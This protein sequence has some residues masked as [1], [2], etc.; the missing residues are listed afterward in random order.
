MPGGFSGR[1]A[2]S[3]LGQASDAQASTINTVRQTPSH[4]VASAS[5]RQ[6]PH[7]PE[8]AATG[9]FTTGH[10]NSGNIVADWREYET[11]SS[12]ISQADEKMGECLYRAAQE[13]EAMCQTIFVMPAAVP[14]C[15]NI[16]DSVKQSLSHFRSLTE[17]V[18]MLAR[19]YADEVTSIG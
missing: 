2:A 13:I 12:Q 19:R 17:E 10:G 8:E 7:R 18:A 1:P 15:L 5:I 6:L 4:G 16:S 14:R 9:S 3:Y 11:V